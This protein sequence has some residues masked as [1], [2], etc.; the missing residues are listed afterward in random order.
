MSTAPVPYT[1][2]M[3]PRTLQQAFPGYDQTRCVKATPTKFI[4]RFL[5]NP[6]VALWLLSVV[7]LSTMYAF[8]GG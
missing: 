6:A 4:W 2:R 8:F 7:M 5:A 1:E 3:Y